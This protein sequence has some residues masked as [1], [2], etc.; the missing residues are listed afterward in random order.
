M[1]P[2][3]TPTLTGNNN[4]KGLSEAS[5]DGLSTAAKKWPTP[6]A[7]RADQATTHKRG[8]P[9]LAMVTNAWPTPRASENENR[10]RRPAPSHD[11]NAHG[12]TLAG[13]AGV[14]PSPKN[15][16]FRSPAGESTLERDSP[17]LN[18]VAYHFGLR[19]QKTLTVGLGC[20]MDDLTSRQLSPI[21]T[22]WLMGLP[23]NW[24]NPLW[25]IDPAAFEAWETRSC[26]WLRRL[27]S[28]GSGTES[29][30]GGKRKEPHKR[31][32]AVSGNLPFAADSHLRQSAVSG[33]SP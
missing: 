9:T 2:W 1:F 31:G 33:G 5:G 12:K 4:R 20:S 30:S 26:R 25:R 14:W 29:P 6:K 21:F 32:T 24:S 3:P 27:L 7:E 28:A 16:D 23:E 13:E 18:V 11:G 19:V 15:R 22:E 17:D 10:T 8:N